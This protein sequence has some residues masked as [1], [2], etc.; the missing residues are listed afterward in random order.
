MVDAL[1]RMN[2][3][4]EYQEGQSRLLRNAAGGNQ[5]R[6]APLVGDGVATRLQVSL[7]VLTTTCLMPPRTSRSP[8]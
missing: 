2:R 6:D 8:L 7:F 1:G 4:G 5:G 3:R